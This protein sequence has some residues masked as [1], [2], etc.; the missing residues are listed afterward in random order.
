MKL[1]K[2][3]GKIRLVVSKKE[4]RQ[5][6]R[7]LNKKAQ[8]LDDNP[9]ENPYKITPYKTIQDETAPNEI[10]TPDETM[11]YTPEMKK[12]DVKKSYI[13]IP[14]KE[15]LAISQSKWWLEKTPQEIA[16][17]QI[18]TNQLCCPW[19]VFH[20]AVETTLGESVTAYGFATLRELLCIKILKAV[21]K[22]PPTLNEIKNL[23]LYE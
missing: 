4:F 21:Q 13:N 6:G 17:I 7:K 14:E 16:R 8:I 2:K 22:Q 19:D 5:I 10:I 15:A 1:I 23:K 9:N 18:F 11:T 20:E 3:A 12:E